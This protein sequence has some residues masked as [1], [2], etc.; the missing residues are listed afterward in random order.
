MR[1][2]SFGRW[3]RKTFRWI[4]EARW[5]GWYPGKGLTRYPF[6]GATVTIIQYGSSSHFMAK[7]PLPLPWH[8]HTVFQ[9]M[10]HDRR[11]LVE[12]ESNW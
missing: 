10:L 7:G 4:G 3:D 6:S 12:F 8:I 5:L 11:M 1:I 2:S 9:Q